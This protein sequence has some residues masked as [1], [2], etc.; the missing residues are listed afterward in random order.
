MAPRRPRP[1]CTHHYNHS[2][3][4]AGNDLQ[5]RLWNGYDAYAQTDA[6]IRYIR[7]RGPGSRAFALFLS[8]GPPHDPSASAPMTRPCSCSPAITA[9]C[10]S[11]TGR[12]ATHTGVRVNR[13]AMTSRYASRS[14]C[15]TR[16]GSV[17]AP[18]WSWI[19]YSFATA[20]GPGCSL[21]MPKIRGSQRRLFQS[22]ANVRIRRCQA[23][24]VF[25]QLP[26]SKDR[27]LICRHRAIQYRLLERVAFVRTHMAQQRLQIRR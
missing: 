3:F 11:P 18:E 23:V 1:E 21:T 17:P 10:L 24:R 8:F 2:Q 27:S 7:D 6:A 4:Y 16:R 19:P 26:E 22:H 15:A 12:Q 14:C 25:L 20:T 9:I 13:R 5:P